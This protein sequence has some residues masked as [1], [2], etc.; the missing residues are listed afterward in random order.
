MTFACKT[1]I[2]QRIKQNEIETRKNDV[3]DTT[4]FEMSIEINS[5]IVRRNRFSRVETAR[6]STCDISSLF[7]SL[8]REKRVL[9]GRRG[10]GG[11]AMEEETEGAGRH[12]SQLLPGDKVWR[13]INFIATQFPRESA[14]GAR[15]ALFSFSR[16]N[17]KPD[18]GLSTPLDKERSKIREKGKGNTRSVIRGRMKKREK[19]KKKKKK[20]KR[21][22]G[23]GKICKS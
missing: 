22:C 14:T 15:G 6:V 12:A 17:K 23:W 2:E 4:S 8:S 11:R 1:F 21:L 7:P 9:K 19:K 16:G 20:K 10:W 3:C 13:I 18:K 5:S